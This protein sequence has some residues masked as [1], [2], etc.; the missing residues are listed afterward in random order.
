VPSENHSA[1]A[2]STTIASPTS[3]PHQ[4]YARTAAGR[5]VGTGA[6]PVLWIQPCQTDSRRRA[7]N[8]T[9]PSAEQNREDQGE[10]SSFSLPA[11][12]AS[13]SKKLKMIVRRFIAPQ[14]T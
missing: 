8:Q 7:E 4:N 13:A 6:K 12:H 10:F 14:A 5:R 3:T 2:I 1:A 11:R 9:A